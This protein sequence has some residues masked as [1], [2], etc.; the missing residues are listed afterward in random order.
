M[1]VEDIIAKARE[2]NR[3]VLSE[4]ESKQVL[5]NIGLPITKQMLVAEE[6]GLDAALAACDQIGYPVVMKLMAQ[7]IIHKSDAGA[8][9]LNL[10]DNA[11]SGRS[12][13]PITHH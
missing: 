3:L 7:N 12:I 13:Q 1:S 11:G 9:K 10:K 2:E 8:V 5:E 4:F 6:E